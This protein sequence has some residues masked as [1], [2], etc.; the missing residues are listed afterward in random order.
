MICESSILLLTFTDQGK[1][2]FSAF[3]GIELNCSTDIDDNWFHSFSLLFPK[4]YRFDI[5]ARAN[6]EAIAKVNSSLV[7]FVEIYKPNYIIYPCNFSGIVTTQTLLAIR[8][9]GSIVVGF[10][11]DDDVYF[12]K[13]SQW[14]IP[15]LDYCVTHSLKYVAEY[16][17]LGARSIFSPTIP[18]STQIFSR[19]ENI[20]IKYDVTF[21][22]SLYA[23]RYEYIRKINNY[24][25]T[26]VKYLG[27]GIDNKMDFSQ[28]VLAIN[29]SSINLNFSLNNNLGQPVNQIKGRLFEVTLCGGF[30]LTEYAEGLEKYFL[31]GTEIETFKSPEEAA[32][33]INYY[34]KHPEE[35][36]L[37]AKNGY[38]RAVRD[39]KGES[40]LSAI[41]SKLV[42]DLELN[43]R[44]EIMTKMLANNSLSLMEAEQY[45]AWVK[46][47]LSCKEPMRCEWI[48]INEFVLSANPSHLGALR[49]KKRFMIWGDPEPIWGRIKNNIYAHKRFFHFCIKYTTS[50]IR[51]LFSEPS[52]IPEAIRITLNRHMR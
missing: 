29:R 8:K 43:G 32:E 9:M 41:F 30:L 22:G 27:G 1:S 13:Y 36:E 44:P 38:D 14:M 16:S 31:L 18:M 11:F 24:C 6:R 42:R 34:L 4:T 3:D 21:I 5:Y 47:V 33:K 17:N 35:R 15:Y 7:S 40:V 20:E 52:K 39:Y 28:L 49:L 48:K 26:K 12:Y 2:G 46:A 23:E 19:L 37:I 10:F 50:F 25:A 45:F 51:L